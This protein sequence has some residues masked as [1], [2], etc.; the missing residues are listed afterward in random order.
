MEN[1]FTLY[2][3]T[4]FGGNSLKINLDKYSSNKLHS[5]KEFD[6]H[7]KL[8]SLSWDVDSDVIVV[9]YEHSDGTGRTYTFGRGSGSD[10]STH[11]VDNFKDCNSSWRWI[12]RGSVSVI[13]AFDW[14]GKE[15]K[16]F[17]FP[18]KNINLDGGHF[19]G[20]AC[21]NN[22][23]LAISTSSNSVAKVYI[24]EWH[25]TIGQGE[26]VLVKEIVVGNSPFDHAG[27]IQ[28]SNQV[29]AVG[30]EDFNG[31]KKS[32]VKF[33]DLRN[34]KLPKELVHLEVYRTGDVEERKTAGAVGLLKLREKYLMIAGSWNSGTI[35]F[36]YSNKSNLFDQNCK[37]ELCASWEKNEVDNYDKWIDKNWGGY[38]SLNLVSFD[39]ATIY[40]IGGHI[41]V[42]NWIDLYRIEFVSTKVRLVKV[43]KRPLT[44]SD[45]TSFLYA[46]GIF[47]DGTFLHAVA[48]EKNPHEKTSANLFEGPGGISNTTNSVR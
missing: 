6:V 36:Y 23:T 9:L 1:T 26:G 37:F 43:K 19:Q 44:C 14:I 12:K 48:T 31:K 13:D 38:Q 45:N 40:L 32:K 41:D 25:P 11:G 20:V 47:F 39:N 27:G 24:F 2:E 5:L 16:K 29:L 8:S 46:G 22:Q 7:D 15:G 21:L 3:N 10:S 4:D 33:F 28:I 17:T 34:P 18:G 35:D 30:V 42:R